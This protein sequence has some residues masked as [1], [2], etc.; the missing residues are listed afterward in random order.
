MSGLVAAGALA[1]ATP[2]AA[3]DTPPHQGGAAATLNGLT[4]YD[5]AVLHI[6]G[7]RREIP[8]GLFEMAVD[9]GGTLKTY[10][11]DLHNPT[12]DKARYLETS[13]GQSSL[14]VNRDAGRIRWILQHSYPR[15]DDLAGLARRA[16]SGPLSPQTAAAGTQV[17]I[18]RHSDDAR[19]EAADPAA[20][21]LA[22]WLEKEARNLPE[23]GPSLSL[24]PEAASGPAGSR[25]GPFTVRTSAERVPV[26]L[27]GEAVGGVRVTDQAGKPVTT[28][29]N[30]SRLYLDVPPG[31]ADG[32]ATLSLQA[33]TPVPV[34]RVFTGATRTQT[35]VLAGSS[36]ST[37][38][39]SATASW[40]RSG[41]LPVLT[42]RKNCAERGLDVT[43]AN[44][45]DA[46]FSYVLAGEEYVL[47]PG[48]TR[49]VAVP[50]AEDQPYEVTVSGTDGFTRTF[51][52]L[53][54][55]RT[56]GSAAVAALTTQQGGQPS[57]LPSDASPTPGAQGGA[58]AQ[59]DDGPDLAET[60]ASANTPMIAGIALAL[61][62]LGGGALLLVRG[63]KDTAP[64]AAAAQA[65]PTDD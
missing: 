12:Q 42:A 25:V 50:V 13:W 23:P 29:A 51:H 33:T 21:K 47:Q 3:D 10:C 24:S 53:L 56:T 54:D 57:P 9:G 20:E 39:A 5:T 43:A 35:Q 38:A 11:V 45:G 18:W 48:E 37:V 59:S 15:V 7:E 19:V 2:A 16:K 49:T 14:A 31:A 64:E 55:C 27:S 46:P 40:T 1:A 44:R 32:S 34:G 26:A 36:E 17:A 58:A 63:R 22:D 60:G 4:A 28:A 8:A 30:G 52:G 62:V 6:G 41:A 61:L 65:P